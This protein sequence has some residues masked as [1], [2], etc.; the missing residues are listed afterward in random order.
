MVD[1]RESLLKAIKNSFSCVIPVL[2]ATQN[3]GA[4]DKSEDGKDVKEK[5]KSSIKDFIGSFDGNIFS[6]SFRNPVLFFQCVWNFMA[7]FTMMLSHAGH[8]SV[9]DLLK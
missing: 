4:L 9:G 5:F 1:A 6:F 8:L 2:D 7:C 3:W